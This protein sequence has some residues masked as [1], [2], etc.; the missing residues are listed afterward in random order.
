L[1]KGYLIESARGGAGYVKVI[2]VQ[3]S[4]KNYLK[5]LLEFTESPLSFNEGSSILENICS[6]NFLTLRETNLLKRA[7]SP[8]AVNNPL[9]MDNIIRANILK[10]VIMELLK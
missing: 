1:N 5:T 3:D 7:I 10:E 8:K 4:G 6:K 9:N 2:K